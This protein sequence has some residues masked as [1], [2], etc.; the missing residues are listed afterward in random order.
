MHVIFVE[1]A[2]PRNQREFP[3]ALKAV[4]AKVTGIGESSVNSLDPELKGWLDAYEQ[5]SSVT[6]TQALHDTVKRIQTRGWVDRL[7]STVEAHTEPV[8]KV[9]EAC[10]IPG[11]SVKTAFLCRDKPAMKE[12]LRA[13]GVPCAQSTGT[14]SADEVRSFVKYVGFPVILKPR[15]AAGAAGTFRAGNEAELEQVIVES[16]AANGAPVAVEEFIEG[17]EGFYDTLAIEGKVVH[18]FACHYFPNVLEAMRTRWINPQILVTNRSDDPSYDEVKTMGQKVIRELG[19]GTSATHMEWFFGEKGLKFSEIGCRPPGVR[20]WDL[21]GAA[22]DLDMYV[23]WAKAIV[24]GRTDARAS[25][26]FAAGMIALRPS[27]DGVI[28]G[29]EGVEKIQAAFGKHI[30]DSH[31]PPAGSKTQGV[32]G[33]YMANAWMRLRHTDYDELRKIMNA[34][35]ETVKVHAKPA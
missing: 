32:S 17:H 2:F 34:V 35:G 29:Y 20:V 6:N 14:S 27:C 30:F 31:L 23:E 28:T 9:R 18:D 11:T 33:G 1:P 5:V 19:I 22:N 3:R 25:R 10:S 24:H 15:A 13:A 12:A 21:Y 26:R 16:G 4:G 7:E 8:A